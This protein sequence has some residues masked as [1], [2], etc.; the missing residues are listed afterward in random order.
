M[1]GKTLKNRLPAGWPVSLRASMAPSVAQVPG[2]ET[3]I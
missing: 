2:I 1:D 3:L